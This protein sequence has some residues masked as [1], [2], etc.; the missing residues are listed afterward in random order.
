MTPDWNAKAE[1]E[2]PV[3]Y[4]SLEDPQSLNLYAYVRNNPVDRVDADGHIDGATADEF[5]ETA[6]RAEA[7]TEVVCPECTPLVAAAAVVT[8]GVALYQHRDDIAATAQ[9]LGNKIAS[10]FKK[11][12]PP[13]P[14]KGQTSNAEEGSQEHTKG[15]RGSTYD[16]HTR[17]RSGERQPPNYKSYKR[18]TQPSGEKKKDQE[19]KYFRKDRDGDSTSGSNDDSGGGSN[20]QSNQQ[21]DQGSDQSSG[22]RSDQGGNGH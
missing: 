6:Y 18:Y 8:T 11:S 1:D 5:I 12:P 14:S 13:A 10:F 15:A 7:T 4:A 2:D 16:K 3:P 20:Q 9:S 21:S 17:T 19:R 22:Q